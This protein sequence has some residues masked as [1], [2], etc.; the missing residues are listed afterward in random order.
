M[1]LGNN[2]RNW[3]PTALIWKRFLAKE[4]F[5]LDLVENLKKLNQSVL[6]SIDCSIDLNRVKF[7]Y[8][9]YLIDTLADDQMNLSQEES[10][11]LYHTLHDNV[12]SVLIAGGDAAIFR[13]HRG[14]ECNFIHDRKVL[15]L[16]GYSQQESTQKLFEVWIKGKLKQTLDKATMLGIIEEERD[17]KG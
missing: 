9:Q 1:K 6:E 17:F 3:N 5:N 4:I 14:K 15:S 2:W 8:K 7:D 12:N 10:L 16:S 11:E 13:K